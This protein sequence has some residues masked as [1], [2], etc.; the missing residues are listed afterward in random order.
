MTIADTIRRAVRR[1]GD[2]PAVLANLA[3]V[4]KAALHR[5]M[6]GRDITTATADR[7]CAALGLELAGSG[8]RRKG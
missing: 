3:G 6:R 5:F 4:D 1:S 7:L 8:Q 2:P